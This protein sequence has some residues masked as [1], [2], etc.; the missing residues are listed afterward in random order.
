[1][2]LYKFSL[3]FSKEIW[4]LNEDDKNTLISKGIGDRE[5][6][7]ILPGEGIDCERFRPLPMT[8]E[9][10]KTV[11]LMIARAFIDKGFK[12]YEESARRVRK[13][14]EIKWSSGTWEL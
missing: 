8:R 1:M 4:V 10:N 3:R 12:E 6:I 7:F 9:D 5:K 13:S 14:T 2:A 11:F